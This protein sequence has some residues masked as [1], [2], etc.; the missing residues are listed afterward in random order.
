MY[1]TINWYWTVSYKWKIVDCDLEGKKESDSLR[2]D[3]TSFREIKKHQ[4]RFWF[5]RPVRTTKQCVE[6]KNFRLCFF[7]CLRLRKSNIQKLE[8]VYKVIIIFKERHSFRKIQNNQPVVFFSLFGGKQFEK[9]WAI[10]FLYSKGE[11]RTE[12]F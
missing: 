9:G 8:G 12:V 10:I 7:S 11:L 6:V 1:G 4:I 5:W 2:K 3:L